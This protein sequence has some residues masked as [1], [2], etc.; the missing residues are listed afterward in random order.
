MKREKIMARAI[1][2]QDRLISKW[3]NELSQVFFSFF[4]FMTLS[5]IH[6]IWYMQHMEIHISLVTVVEEYR[7]SRHNKGKGWG[8]KREENKMGEKGG[9]TRKKNRKERKEVERERRI[10]RREGTTKNWDIKRE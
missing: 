4:S 1:V 10:G 7:G 3:Q 8:I 2:F 9:G 6:P 5:G